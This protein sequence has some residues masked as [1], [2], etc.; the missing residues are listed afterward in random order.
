MDKYKVI[1]RDNK[2]KGIIIDVYCD[3]VQ[4]PNGQVYPRE[5]IEHVPG[6][7]VA[8]LDSDNNLFFVT[9]YRYGV[10]KELL[11]L[12]AGKCESKDNDYLLSAKRELE[13]E[14]GVVAANWI[15][16]GQFI[17]TTAYCS[18]IIQLYF[19]Y[20]LTTTKQHLD[21]DEFLE[22]SKINIDKAIDM[23][24]SNEITDG[25]TIALI[26]KVKHYLNNK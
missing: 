9:Q 15:D 14:C 2:Y 21:E 24:M 17:P 19:A 12:P 18:E 20:D 8:A 13:E 7:C 25:K 4:Y 1:K 10:D 3:Q 22:V 23:I 6:V 11:E 26:L 5:I 16:M